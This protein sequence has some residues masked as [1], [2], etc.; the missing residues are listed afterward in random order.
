MAVD[1][2]NAKI[3]VRR[4]WR[5]FA[6]TLSDVL[7]DTNLKR[8]GTP[9]LFLQNIGTSGAVAIAWETNDTVVNIYL[10]QGQVIEGGL[11][12]HAKT[13]GTGAGVSLVGFA[14]NIEDAR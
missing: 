6:I 11:W 12:R 4:W 10:S 8:N 14:G 3:P 9:Y 2:I 1:V 5:P 7:S 13:T